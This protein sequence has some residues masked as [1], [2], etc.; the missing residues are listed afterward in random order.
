MVSKNKG[1]KGPNAMMKKLMAEKGMKTGDE[2][3]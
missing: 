3:E 1:K 2:V